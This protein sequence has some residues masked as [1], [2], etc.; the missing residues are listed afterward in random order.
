M[1]SW[2]GAVS[3]AGKGLCCHGIFIPLWE[4]E[5]CDTPITS[6][7]VR[8]DGQPNPAG[9]AANSRVSPGERHYTAGAQPTS[10]PSVPLQRGRRLLP[11]SEAA[12]PSATLQPGHRPA[13]DLTASLPQ[14]ASS[15]RERG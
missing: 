14:H 3:A 8:Q 11:A 1:G 2:A 10:R 13:A 7:M 9:T 6:A 5:T 4:M 15:A 12:D